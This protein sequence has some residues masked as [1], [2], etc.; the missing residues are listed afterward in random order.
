MG[1]RQLGA[2]L[3]VA[4]VLAWAAYAVLNYMVGLE[5]GAAPFLA[6]HLAGVIPGSYL[7]GGSLI[8]Q[9]ARSLRRR[10]RSRT[11]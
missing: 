8:G 1:R 11:A 5:I 2:G 6:W 9:L 3:I 4:G 7:F 10:R